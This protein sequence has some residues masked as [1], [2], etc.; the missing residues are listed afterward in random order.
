MIAVSNYSTLGGPTLPFYRPPKGAKKKDQK[1]GTCRFTVNSFFFLRTFTFVWAFFQNIVHWGGPLFQNI[2]HWGGP[3]PQIIAIKRQV[4]PPPPKSKGHSYCII[5]GLHTNHL[6]HVTW[7]QALRATERAGPPSVN[8]ERS[9]QLL[10]N[11][12]LDVE[13]EQGMSR[14]SREQKLVP[15]SP[16]KIGG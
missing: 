13:V 1:N 6:Y 9:W 10:R 2:V 11:T 15:W 16:L 12:L 4:G 3:P 8:E 14:P 5:V 7:R